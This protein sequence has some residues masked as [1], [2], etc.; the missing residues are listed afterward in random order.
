M[1]DRDELQAG[2]SIF[3]GTMAEM[4]ADEVASAARGGAVAL[5]ALGVI[6]QH[7]PH[8]PTGTDVY[9]PAAKLRRLR[10]LL[11][12]RGIA[13]VIVPPYYWGVNH[14]S[15]AFPAS[16]KVRPEVMAEL[17]SDVIGSLD[18]DGFTALFCVTGHGDADHNRTIY[19]G[20]RRGSAGRSIRAS[21]LAEA[22]L[23]QRL[24]L[25]AADPLVT[26]FEPA[27]S[28]PP[29]RYVDVH[30]GEYETS[31]MLATYP[32]L[33]RREVLPSL[34]PTNFGPEDLNEWRRGLDHARRKTPLGYLGDP[35]AASLEQGQRSL[36]AQATAMAEAIARRLA[37]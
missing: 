1:T 37:A 18:G 32:G 6:E 5:W 33:V 24:G 36:E 8:L 16:P 22:R 17:M 31:A 21:F 9:L 23:V 30:A 2:I 35:A 4:T 10:A 15:G 26:P 25:D 27:P 34:A 12:E 29:R 3:A 14:V 19:E 20:I 13:A 11:A 28:G 7:G